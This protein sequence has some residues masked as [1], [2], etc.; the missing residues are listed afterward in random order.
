MELMDALML[1]IRIGQFLGVI[2]ILVILRDHHIEIDSLKRTINLMRIKH[3]YEKGFKK[4]PME[5]E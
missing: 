3:D 1:G 2:G 5:E 4:T